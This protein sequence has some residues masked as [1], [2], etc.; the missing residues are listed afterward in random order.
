MHAMTLAAPSQRLGSMGGLLALRLAWQAI[1][2]VSLG[3]QAQKTDIFQGLL[4]LPYQVV[5]S[6][7]PDMLIVFPVPGIK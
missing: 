2:C 3:L 7:S 5:H 6:I 4:L 1:R